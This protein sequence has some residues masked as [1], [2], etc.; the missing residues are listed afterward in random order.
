MM[1][2]LV[3]TPSQFFEFFRGVE[4]LVMDEIHVKANLD[5]DICGSCHLHTLVDNTFNKSEHI[6]QQ[7]AL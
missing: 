6:V 5:F 2:R 3:R 4:R 7:C 1:I